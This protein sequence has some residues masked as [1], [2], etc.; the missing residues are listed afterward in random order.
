MMA[1]CTCSCDLHDGTHCTNQAAAGDD[2]CGYC[3]T[4]C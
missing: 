3:Q 4:Y 1:T 2:Y